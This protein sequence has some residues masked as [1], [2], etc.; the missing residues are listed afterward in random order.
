MAGSDT[1]FEQRAHLRKPL[2]IIFSEPTEK[3]GDR[4]AIHPQHL[5]RQYE[6][7]ATG[8]L[9]AAGPFTNE[10]GKPQGPGMIIIRAANEAEARAVA[11]ADP[12]HQQGFRKYRLQK[13]MLNEGTLGLRVNLS[14]QTISVD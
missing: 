8:V 12:Y 10:D 2:Y 5:A 13:W 4:H 6:L 14:N 7:E 3:A 9:F 11:D 1:G